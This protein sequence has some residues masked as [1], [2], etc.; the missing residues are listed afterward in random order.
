MRHGYLFGAAIVLSLAL[1]APIPG[2][3]CFFQVYPTPLFVDSGAHAATIFV[4]ANFQNCTW[5]TSGG[6]AW[7]SIGAGMT[8]S[9]STSLTISANQTG[10]DRSANITVA[11]QTVELTQRFTPQYFTDVFPELRWFNGVSLL[12]ERQITGGCGLSPLA[13]CG[14]WAARREEIAVFVVR[15][16]MGGDGFTFSPTPYFNDVPAGHPYFKWIQK[17]RELGITV[18]C[19][20]NRYC[21]EHGITRGELAVLL[22]RARYGAADNFAFSP[23][24]R[25]TDVPAGHPYFQWIQKMGQESLT[26][27]CS[28]AEYCPEILVFRGDAATLVM[29]AGFNRLLPAGSPLISNVSPPTGAQGT[30]VTVVVS[31]LFT[32]FVQGSTQLSAGAGI[33]VSN[34]VVTGATSLTATLT[35]DAGAAAGPRTLVA[36]TGGSEATLPN[37]FQVTL[38]N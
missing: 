5:D 24:A 6:T 35:I 22:I 18:G 9:G 17:L 31:G 33:A 20:P 38:G 32:S 19:A 37:G 4:V 12:F 25:Y 7:A 15:A 21:P 13:F 26:A 11:G 29:R 27:G 3:T 16:V 34:V 36:T 28:P 23:N 14:Y 2:Q 1:P 8:G 10:A 30:A